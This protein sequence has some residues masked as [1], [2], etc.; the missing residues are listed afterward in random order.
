M[1]PRRDD[2][3]T[4]TTSGPEVECIPQTRFRPRQEHPGGT[5]TAQA[6]LYLAAIVTVM[7]LAGCV[8]LWF[9]CHD[10]ARFSLAY[11]GRESVA[12]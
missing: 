6:D 4:V 10:F 5:V 11:A 2:C 12:R 7:F 1:A 3:P 9:L 8:H